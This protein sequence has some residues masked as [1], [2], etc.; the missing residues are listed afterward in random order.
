MFTSCKHDNPEPTY[1]NTVILYFPWTGTKTSSAGGLYAE[2]QANI[3][4]I[5]SAIVQDRG[6]GTNRVMMIIATSATQG[7]LSEIVYNNGKCQEVPIKEYS[8]WSFT[9]KAKIGRAHV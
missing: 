1:T 5:E 8:N 6:L 7:H 3:E 9:T 4:S 2:F